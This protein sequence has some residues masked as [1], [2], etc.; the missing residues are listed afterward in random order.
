M[1]HPPRQGANPQ[2][3]Q[4]V[5]D[6][7][8]VTIAEWLLLAAMESGCGTYASHL[9]RWV[10]DS[11]DKQF[12]VTASEDECR[13]GL[14]ACLRYG[15][16]RLVRNARDEVDDLL[17]AEPAVMPV[18]AE[19]RGDDEVD[20]TPRGAALYRTVAAEWLGPDWEDDLLVWKEFYREEH[21]YCEAEEGLRDIVQEYVERGEVV[22]ASNLVPIG[23]WCVY[24]W[25]QFPSGYRLELNIGD[26]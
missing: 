6:C 11:A 20:F 1:P 22:R 8:N 26:F 9:P 5:L 17:Q 14:E 7:H 23:P 10:A 2:R 21:L 3:L 19:V 15:W 4:H 13:T 12:G 24:W 18:T 16:L 25:E